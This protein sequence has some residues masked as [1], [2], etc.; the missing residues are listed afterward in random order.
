M[1]NST[2]PS[3]SGA[4]KGAI[5]VTQSTI[6]EIVELATR[7]VR[8]CNEAEPESVEVQLLPAVIGRPGESHVCIDSVLE[9]RNSK[10]APLIGL[11]IVAF[12]KEAKV[13]VM[14][15]STRVVRSSSFWYE[16]VGSDIDA[17]NNFAQGIEEEWKNSRLWYSVLTSVLYSCE[18][19][20]KRLPSAIKWSLIGAFVLLGAIILI[21]ALLQ[22]LAPLT[23][24]SS[25]SPNPGV[26]A[27]IGAKGFPPESSL[28][29]T[30][31]GIGSVDRI[32]ILSRFGAFVRFAVF[33]LVGFFGPRLMSLLFPSVVFELGDG[34]RRY[35]SIRHARNVVL[36]S[37]ILLGI[38]LPLVREPLLTWLFE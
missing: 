9:I 37:V 23:I 35:T 26:P 19:S 10:E 6:K 32:S 3:T 13:M 30:A 22:V 16:A 5:L 12:A 17:V 34:V 36:I 14:I 8:E 29:E 1:I 7:F 21:L 27:E 28:G 4:K 24:S 20:V 2:L 11:M 33:A 15:D 25:G 18:A 38:V 31:E